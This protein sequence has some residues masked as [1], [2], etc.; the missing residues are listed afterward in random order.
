M[1]WGFYIK[2]KK[3]IKKAPRI[4]KAYSSSHVVTSQHTYK[5]NKLHPVDGIIFYLSNPAEKAD[6]KPQRS[7][8]WNLILI[9]GLTLSI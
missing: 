9:S 5:F 3:G 1:L 2:K 4:S 8:D 7:N 6:P